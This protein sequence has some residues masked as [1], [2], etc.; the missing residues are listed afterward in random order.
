M[1]IAN[2]RLVCRLALCLR[3]SWH[4]CCV[5]TSCCRTAPTARRSA[6]GGARL[7]HRPRLRPRVQRVSGGGPVS[8]FGNLFQKSPNEKALEEFRK[9]S[10]G[11]QLERE[12]EGA[13]GNRDK[14]F[15]IGDVALAGVAAVN[16]GR[17]ISTPVRV[18]L[19]T[20]I[21]R[22]IDIPILN[23]AQE[24]VSAVLDPFS[25]RCILLGTRRCFRTD[26]VSQSFWILGVTAPTQVIFLKLTDVICDQMEKELHRMPQVQE[27][28]A[29][30][31]VSP[32]RSPA[33]HCT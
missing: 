24:Q 8:L 27:F 17:L 18:V 21:N 11:A 13:G 4:S 7:G 26:A 12:L 16:E 22:L 31:N 29:E 28:L 2:L 32:P 1:R 5:T 6:L 20:V 15:E 10:R 14:L 19:A 33:G 3:S 23:E 30:L 9:S 25:S